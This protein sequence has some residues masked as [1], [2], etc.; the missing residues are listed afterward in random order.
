MGNSIGI[1]KTSPEFT[2]ENDEELWVGGHLKEDDSPP[3]DNDSLGD[4]HEKTRHDNIRNGQ[5]TVRFF[6]G[7]QEADATF[8]VTVL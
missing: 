6:E 2:I 7:G 5:Q 1:N 4:R 3:N 8:K